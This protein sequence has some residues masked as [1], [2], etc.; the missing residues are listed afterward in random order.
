MNGSL[1]MA[2]AS[3]GDLVDSL[4][5]MEGK[6]GSIEVL[7]CPPSIL[8]GTVSSAIGSSHIRCGSQDIDERESGAFTGQISASMVADSGATHTLI[9]HSERRTLFGE[10]DESVARKTNAAL[11]ANLI[12]VIC[13][14][15]TREERETSRTESVVE[16]QIRAVTKHCGISALSQVII[17]YEPVWA[18]G[19]GLTATPEQ[20]QQ[21]HH[22]IRQLLAAEDSAIAE[23]CRILYGGSMKPDNAPDLLAQT[24]IDGGLIGGASLNSKDFFAICAAA[25]EQAA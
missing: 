5:S 14:G 20:A 10:S 8:L 19:T 22:F 15:E 21:V 17:A 24:D 13:V 3:C 6:A 25:I 2:R 7:L 4:A 18:I 23:G 1:E 16:R 11:Q 9:G 12:P